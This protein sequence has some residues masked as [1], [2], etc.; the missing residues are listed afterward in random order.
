MDDGKENDD[1]EKMKVQVIEE[2][3]GRGEKKAKRK[4][5]RLDASH[6]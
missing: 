2:R 6:S 1:G 3:V 4:R 5:N